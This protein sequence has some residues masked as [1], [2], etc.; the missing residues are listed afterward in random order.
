MM[1]LTKTQQGN[2]EEKIKEIV[3]REIRTTV[4]R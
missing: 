4:I 2:M 3:A 1:A